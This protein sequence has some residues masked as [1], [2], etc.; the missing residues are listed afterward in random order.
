[1]KEGDKKKIYVDNY[2]EMLALVNDLELVSF[3]EDGGYQGEYLAVLKDEERLFY[4]IGS[5]GSCSGCDWL[6]DEN[7]YETNEMGKAYGISYK[8]ALDY[9]GGIKPKYIVPK[10]MPL[11]YIKKGEYKGFA[12]LLTMKTIQDFIKEKGAEF[13]KRFPNLNDST[14][15]G[16]YDAKEYVASF[17]TSSLQEAYELG[18][19]SVISKIPNEKMHVL[20]DG[21]NSPHETAEDFGWNSCIR[22]IKKSLETNK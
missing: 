18:R 6:E 11:K 21:V 13:S 1:M 10:N 2:G 22:E 8:N 20:P 14:E 15:E 9:C 16:G 12:I 3:E 7:D 4:Y 17:L 19:E 5:Y